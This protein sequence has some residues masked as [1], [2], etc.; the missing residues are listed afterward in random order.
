V[1]ISITF[2][3][4]FL[5]YLHHCYFLEILCL[6][7]Y[8]TPFELDGPG[9]TLPVLPSAEVKS[10]WSYSSS[11]PIHLHVAHHHVHFLLTSNLSRL[12]SVLPVTVPHF[13]RGLLLQ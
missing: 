12:L 11:P 8:L 7:I 9:E 10:G 6:F 4:V 5:Q 2:N 3:V 13:A 1:V